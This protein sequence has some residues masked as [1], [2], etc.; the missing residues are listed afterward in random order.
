M[1]KKWICNIWLESS[2]LDAAE[3]H[4]AMLRDSPSV[5]P[6]I[7]DSVMEASAQQQQRTA[8]RQQ[9]EQQE[10]RQEQQQQR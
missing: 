10:Q 7:E 3:M 5:Q 4:F 1:A 6:R 2:T 8:A 9:Q